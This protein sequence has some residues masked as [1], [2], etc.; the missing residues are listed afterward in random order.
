MSTGWSN[1]ATMTLACTTTSA[2]V[3]IPARGVADVN[4]NNVNPIRLGGKV[5]LLCLTGSLTGDDIVYVTVG[6]VSVVATAANGMPIIP[7]LV[8]TIELQPTD[9]HIAAITSANGVTL[10]ISSGQET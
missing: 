1:Y 3:A 9:T 4:T 8:D 6:D 10:V 2:R 7:G 5:R